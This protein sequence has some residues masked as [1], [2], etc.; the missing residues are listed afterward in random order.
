MTP[1]EGGLNLVTQLHLGVVK[2]KISKIFARSS[3]YVL[4]L[5]RKMC[6]RLHWRAHYFPALLSK[7]C[8][9]FIW[10]ILDSCSPIEQIQVSACKCKTKNQ[11][12][13]AFQNIFFSLR[14]RPA[15]RTWKR[16]QL[17]TRSS[18]EIFTAF[19]DIW[20][21]Q[22]QRRVIHNF[23]TA[24]RNIEILANIFQPALTIEK[25]PWNET[26][27]MSPHCRP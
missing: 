5:R 21:L 15:K 17:C 16:Y 3:M 8:E 7:T 18:F 12:L 10:G 20:C 26:A 13:Q 24:S 27:G 1:T 23:Y 4:N 11:P 22:Q 25:R 14:K 9:N 6:F 19:S 2:W